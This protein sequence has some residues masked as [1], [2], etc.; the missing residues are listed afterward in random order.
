MQKV[1]LANV[2]QFPASPEVESEGIEQ[3]LIGN[4]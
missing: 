1:S 2:E 3:K 4:D